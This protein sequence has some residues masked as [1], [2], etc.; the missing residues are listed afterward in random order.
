[1]DSTAVVTFPNLQPGTLTLSGTYAGDANWQSTTYTDALPITV[2]VSN[3]FATTT[4]LTVGPTT[5]S[6]ATSVKLS[7]TV[8]GGASAKFSPPGNV[9]FYVGAGLVAIANLESSGATSSTAV[10]TIPSTALSNGS[11]QVT[12]QYQGD[13]GLTFNPSTSAPVTD[14]VTPSAFEMAFAQTQL[15]I[16][17]GQSGTASL[18]LT[19]VNGASEA[20]VLSCAPSSGSITCSVSPASANAGSCA[21]VTVNAFVVGRTAATFAWQRGLRARMASGK[22]ATGLVLLILLA[23]SGRWRLAP[24]LCIFA[25]LALQVA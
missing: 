9:D 18:I 13:F 11:D 16:K 8:Q 12:A 25:I 23:C 1:M 14:S 2:A 4:T 24:G 3:L 6:S 20:V 22:W 17:S 7:A 10:I 19:G 15:E 5:I 21:V